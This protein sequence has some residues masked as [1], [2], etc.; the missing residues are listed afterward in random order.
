MHEGRWE[1]GG[2]REERGVKEG[3]RKKGKR[4]EGRG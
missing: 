3:R 1:R 2:K 4:G